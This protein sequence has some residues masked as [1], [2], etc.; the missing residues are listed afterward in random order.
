MLKLYAK[1]EHL[2]DLLYTFTSKDWKFDNSNTRKMWSLLN[3]EDREMFW[4]SFENFNW[5]QYIK[6][7]IHGIRKHIHRE[8]QSNL[9]KALA[10][11]RRL[12]FIC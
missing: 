2:T 4:Y 9:K 12:D 1:L 7:Y 10:K 3:K 8:D 6:I 5:K 11:N